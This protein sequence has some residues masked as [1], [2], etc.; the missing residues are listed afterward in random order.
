MI[1]TVN[2]LYRLHTFIE[3]FEYLQIKGS[4]GIATFGHDRYL[5]QMLYKSLEWKRIRDEV[6]IR[7]NGCDLG[8]EDYPIYTTVVVHHM[9]PISIEDLLAKDMSVLDPKYLITTSL[10]THQAIHYGNASI[11]EKP[12]VE[13]FPG[14]TKLW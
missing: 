2:E 5:N 8:I 11:L 10:R 3:R 1:R 4:I 12:F 13:R 6:I 14:D 7:D 9:N